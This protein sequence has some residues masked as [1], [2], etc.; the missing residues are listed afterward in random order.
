MKEYDKAIDSY[1]QAIQINPKYDLA[2]NDRGYAYREKGDY[3]KAIDDYT[4]IIQ[5]NPE[6]YCAYINRG[7]IYKEKG[8]YDKAIADYTQ[9]IQIDPKNS[10]GYYRRGG[11]YQK[12]D[13]YDK[14]IENYTQATQINP[15]A[16]GTYNC[17]SWL[18]S[19]CPD[20]RYRNGEKALEFAKK[21]TGLEPNNSCFRDT[22]AAAYAEAGKFEDAVKN[23]EKA[24]DML[25][26]KDKNTL[27]RFTERL[28]FYKAKKPWRE[29]KEPK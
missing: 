11:G 5:I 7:D 6:F 26:E 19:T 1:T 28:N 22:L 24:I 12:K 8:E 2:Y 18:F 9:A 23:Q 27:S 4:K 16:A 20:G 13:D 14:A 3:G 10:W 15:K 25:N 21:A 17:V 29:K